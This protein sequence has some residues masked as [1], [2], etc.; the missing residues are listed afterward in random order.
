MR[1]ATTS[2]R[3]V[4][5]PSGRTPLPTATR[6]SWICTAAGDRHLVEFVP[7]SWYLKNPETV[8]QWQFGLTTADFREAQQVDR[9]RE[10]MEMAEGKR[11]FPVGRSGEEA[12]ELMK[13]LMGF[14]TVVSNVNLPNRGQMQQL[15]LGSIVETNCVFSND[16]VKPVLSNPLPAGAATLVAQNCHNIDTCF[17]GIRQR[18]MDKIFAS[19]VNQ[20]L[21]SGLS[22]PD[23]RRLFREMCEHTRAYLEPYYR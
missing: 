20:P 6:S 23:A 21:C 12:V 14:G 8:R 7:G 17:E 16:Q 19:F 11:P 3:A 10:T 13:A 1:R 2:S 5:L 9:I 4:D 22:L 15:P 18:D